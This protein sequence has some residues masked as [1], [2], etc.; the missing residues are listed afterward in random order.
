V[1]C[2]VKCIEGFSN[3]VSNMNRRY[4]DHMKFAACMALSFIPFLHILLVTG[5]IIM[6]VLYA[7]V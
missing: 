1:K 2:L 4:I 6:V 5:I 3:R 7:S